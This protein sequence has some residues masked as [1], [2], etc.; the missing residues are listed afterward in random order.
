LEVGRDFN[1]RG[2]SER[3]KERKE[4]KRKETSQQQLQAIHLFGFWLDPIAELYMFGL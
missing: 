3:P 2:L 1:I 4:K